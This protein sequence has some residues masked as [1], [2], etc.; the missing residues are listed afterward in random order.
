MVKKKSKYFLMFSLPALAVYTVF[1]IVPVFLGVYISFTDWNGIV[2]LAEAQFTGFKNYWNLFRDSI[3]ATSVLNNLKYGIIMLLVVPAASFATA[4]LVENFTKKKVFWRTITY[5][6]AM[7]P[8][9]VAVFLWKWIY[10]PQYG[11]L[12]E[13]LKAVGL[14]QLATGWI[15]NTQTALYAVTFTSLWKTV[16]VYFVLFLAGLQSV[17]ADLV[18]AAVLDG[19]G[20]WQ[21]IKHVTIPCLHRIITI[22]YVLVFIDIFR[23]FDLIYTMTKGGPGYYTTETILTYSY[24]TVFTNSNAGYGMAM[25]SALT[26]FVVLCSFAQMKIQNRMMD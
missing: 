13:F 15:T 12:N 17:P 5:L 18:E 8:T 23:V 11:I 20:R 1:W 9:I 10:N 25:I 3:L 2:N 26:L 22:V 21:V 24:K 6:P 4:Y 19:A 14:G 16:P 7:I